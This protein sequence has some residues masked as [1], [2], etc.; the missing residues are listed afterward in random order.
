MF[1]SAEPP[2]VAPP[3]VPWLKDSERDSCSQPGLALGSKLERALRT[4]A[5]P[6]V[7]HSGGRDVPEVTQAERLATLKAVSEQTRKSKRAVQTNRDTL[8]RLWSRLTPA[9]APAF[10]SKPTLMLLL[11]DSPTSQ[12]QL[13]LHEA[14]KTPAIEHAVEVLLTCLSH[15]M[16]S[17]HTAKGEQQLSVHLAL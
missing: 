2:P 7:K 15:A 17:H 10:V 16:V 3:P 11:T 1:S 13:E 14:L 6:L 5:G 9:A 12:F 8:E 4:L